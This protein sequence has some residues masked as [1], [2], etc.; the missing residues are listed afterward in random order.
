M[1]QTKPQFKLGSRVFSHY[2][3]GWGTVV[4]IGRTERDRYRQSTGKP[5]DRMDDTT[6]YDVWQDK[7]GT[8]LLDDAHGNWEMARIVPEHIAKRYGYGADPTTE[9]RE[10]WTIMA[11]GVD[12]RAHL[13][14]SLIEHLGYG[15][16][17]GPE[18]PA[19]FADNVLVAMGKRSMW[20]SEFEPRD[21]WTEG[22]DEY[23]RCAGLLREA[24]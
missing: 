9:M 21:E 4:K 12:L 1:A 8:E 24:R 19:G 18:D 6:W 7:G 13:V 11:Y 15:N 20:G 22:Y 16:H 17:V 10:H 14:L 3:M 5:E 2:T 23:A